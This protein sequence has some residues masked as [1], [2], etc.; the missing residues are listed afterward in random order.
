LSHFSSP[1]FDMVIFDIQSHLMPLWLLFVL[2]HIDGM[3]GTHYCTQP[4]VK[5]EF[6]EHFSWT[7]LKSWSSWSLTPEY[8]ESQAGATVP[9]K[10]KW[11][12]H[13]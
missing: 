12:I 3:T 6:C 4:L 5:M 7:R 10:N 2:L 13:N 8:I 11:F 9:S 1:L